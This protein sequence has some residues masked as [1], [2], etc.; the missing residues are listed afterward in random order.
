M[1]NQHQHHSA[2]NKVMIRHL[3]RLAYVYV[4]QSSPKQVER[5]RESQIYQYQLSQRAEDLGWSADRIR[6]I[7]ADLGL[8]AQ[9]SQYRDGFQELVT[10]VSLGHVGIIF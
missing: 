6:V 8:S 10:E 5:N 4:R 3:E 2:S 7:D 1:N 9:G